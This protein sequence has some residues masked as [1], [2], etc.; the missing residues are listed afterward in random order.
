MPSPELTVGSNVYFII[1]G[2][3]F[4]G[5]LHNK[6]LLPQWDP[7]E[8]VGEVFTEDNQ[9][10]YI[11]TSELYTSCREARKAVTATYRS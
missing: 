11:P 6:I 4:S 5:F 7:D 9:T 1:L 8:L 2:I 3:V 10:L